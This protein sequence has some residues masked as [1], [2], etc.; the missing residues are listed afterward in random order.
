MSY[1]SLRSLRSL[2]FMFILLA[3]PTFSW[4]ESQDFRFVAQSVVVDPAQRTAVFS[5]T[6]SQTPSFVAVDGT[7]LQSFQYEIDA[8]SEDASTPIAFNTIDAVVRGA[9]I[10]AGNGHELPIRDR[11]GAGGPNAGGWGP[12]RAIV[13]FELTDDTLTFT[14]SWSDIGDQD[15]KFRYRVFT[16]DVGSITADAQ[17]STAAIPLPAGMWTGM[18]TLGLMG[19]GLEIHRRAH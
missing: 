10:F 12:V 16:S 4:A 9:E 13:P 14:T 8:D 19:L 15:G 17:V 2:P 18:I 6:F 1:P 7:Q 3:V 11:Q 5:L